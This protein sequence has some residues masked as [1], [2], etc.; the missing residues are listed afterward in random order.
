M[1]RKSP[2]SWN[3]FI[4]FYFGPPFANTYLTK[5]TVYKC[6]DYNHS[7]KCFKKENKKDSF[8]KPI[9]NVQN[10]LL[11]SLKCT[12]SM[13]YSLISMNCLSFSSFFLS[14]LVLLWPEHYVCVSYWCNSKEEELVRELDGWLWVQV[15]A[16]QESQFVGILARCWNTNGAG[17]VPVQ[18][19]HLESQPGAAPKQQQWC[20]LALNKQTATFKPHSNWPEYRWI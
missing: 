14:V 18:M 15:L 12:M 5:Y 20:V 7:V 8:Y 16:R 4:T 1:F 19:A 13:Y 9:Y 11:W 17:P 2:H 6:W 3:V 10:C